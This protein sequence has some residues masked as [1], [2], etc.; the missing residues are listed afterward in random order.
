[1]ENAEQSL[2]A[3]VNDLLAQV[4]GSLDEI[5]NLAAA[6]LLATFDVV[7]SKYLTYTHPDTH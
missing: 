4:G 2:R 5:N 6:V 3:A 7:N 1:M